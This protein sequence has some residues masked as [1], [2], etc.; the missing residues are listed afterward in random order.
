MRDFTQ[1]P[2]ITIIIVNNYSPSELK[3]VY[4]IIC[5]NLCLLTKMEYG[6][7][8]LHNSGQKAQQNCVIRVSVH[9]L[10]VRHQRHKGRGSDRYVL[11]AA[12]DHVDEAAQ[13]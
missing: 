5:I 13:E 10:L 9:Y 8:K 3:T 1:Q 12:E 7:E 4:R 11:A 6:H 2:I